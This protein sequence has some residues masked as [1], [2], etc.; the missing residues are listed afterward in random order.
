M[1]L[2]GILSSALTALQTNSSALRVVSQNVANINTPGYARR[3]VNQQTQT[4]GGELSGVDI[5]SI[6]RVVDQYYQ[7]ETLS[8][9]AS[10]AQY[11]AE[12]TVYNQLNALLGQPGDG[13][14][15]TSQLD[16]VLSSL[17]TASLDASSNASRQGVLNSMQSLAST[18]STLSGSVANLQVQTDQQVSSSIGTVNDLVKQIYDLNQ[19]IQTQEATG[20]TSSG[21]LDQ[22][23]LA[24]QSLS[25]YVGVRT[26]TQSN[27]A[28]TVMTQDGITL[29]GDTYA[30]LSYDGGSTN[31]SFG[32]ITYTNIN[33][34]TGQVIG[35]AQTLDSHLGSG[36]LKGL[37]DMRDQTLGQLQTELG[38]FA[39]KTALA[40]N[41]VSN[42]NSAYPPPTELDGR[43][44]GLLSTDALNFT[45]KTTIGITDSS[46]NL[47]S[48][49]DVNFDAGTLSVDGGAAQ[50]L[51]ATM[52]DFAT[53]LNSALGSN[54]SASFTNGELSISGSSGN[55][56]VVQDDATTPSS[57]GGV[58]FSQFF[59][60]ND[61][62]QS[63]APSVLTTGLSAGDDS[64]IAAGSEIDFVLRGPDGQI[65]KQAS[66]TMTAGMSIGDVVNALNG[67]MGSAGTFQ[68]KSDGSISMT[69]SAANAGYALDVTEDST[70]RG[71]TGMSFTKLFGIGTQQQSAQASNFSVASAMKTVSNLPFAQPSITATTVAGDSVV[72]PGDGRGIA[73]FET[74]LSSAQNFAAA[75]GLNGQSGTLGDYAGMYYQ[76]V[77]TR[78]ASS[79]T[80]QT[81][82]DDRLT[83]AQSQ[84]ASSSGVNLDEELSNMMVYQQAYSAGARMLTV[85]QS[86]Y[87]TLLQ[88][89]T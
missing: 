74:M 52:G 49:V 40:F 16:N 8:A 38:Q 5:S 51:G 30:K 31:G 2:N 19:Q 86:L 54:G 46:G 29:V 53:A 3:V 22:R 75:G 14:S 63:A 76:D 33:P 35:Q 55:G 20:N 64:G 36:S 73:A 62:F 11:D 68:L 34:A 61:V 80:N 18:V 78:T 83:E 79:Q 47:V 67:A 10:S 39:Q 13:T 45:G 89:G 28:M 17:S 26:G 6:Q 25:Q 32:A 50:P 85:V 77:S 56:V 24:V 82:Q 48:R 81:T 72:T 43:N 44:T 23:D 9:S 7:S 88:V 69:P 57:R 15:L 12:G 21:L 84:L 4:I 59:G 1:S 41:K 60:L 58:G 27:G 70:Q 87:D 37:I 42:A 71:S 66:V 65:A